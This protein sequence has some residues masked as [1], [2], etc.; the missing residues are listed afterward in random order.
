MLLGLPAKKTKYVFGSCS[1][2]AL[3]T[4][5]PNTWKGE[6]EDI[7]HQTTRRTQKEKSQN[8]RLKCCLDAMFAVASGEPGWYQLIPRAENLGVNYKLIRERSRRPAC[9]QF[10]TIQWERES[11]RMKERGRLDARANKT[12]M[13]LPIRELTWFPKWKG[14]PKSGQVCKLEPKFLQ[15]PI[16]GRQDMV[17][18]RHSHALPATAPALEF[19]LPTSGWLRGV[20]LSLCPVHRH[21]WTL[22]ENL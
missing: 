12:S 18:N 13:W 3:N 9:I 8:P 14:F 17:L 15:L 22:G 20:G 11:G 1:S 16:L 2:L 10:L 21:R 6:P 4:L 7:C 5:V 19:P